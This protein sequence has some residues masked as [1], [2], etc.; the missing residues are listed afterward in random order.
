MNR[1]LCLQNIILRFSLYN[2]LKGPETVDNEFITLN[3]V[4]F[5]SNLQLV[6]LLCKIWT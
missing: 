6:E 4:D 3:C 1:V 5:A 2:M